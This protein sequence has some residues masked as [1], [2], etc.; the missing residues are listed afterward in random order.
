MP[1]VLI[2]KI[3]GDIPYH[4]SEILFLPFFRRRANTALP[5]LLLILL[6]NPWRF[7]P[8]ML[9]GV[10]KFFFISDNLSLK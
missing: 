10:F 1:L 6:R 5:F 7:F 8:T 9:V 3:N 4:Q 2:D